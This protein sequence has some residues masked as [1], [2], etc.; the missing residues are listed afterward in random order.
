MGR[1]SGDRS[2][3]SGKRFRRALLHYGS[4][5]RYPGTDTRNSKGKESVLEM[6][7]FSNDKAWS[8]TARSGS[9]G[10]GGWFGMSRR[11]AN[12]LDWEARTPFF[13]VR[14]KGR[15]ARQQGIGKQNRAKAQ[16]ARDSGRRANRQTR[17]Q[18]NNRREY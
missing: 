4:S 11:E 14:A 13:A 1:R 10:G 12:H 18:R 2:N 16:A 8:D 6:G 9:G 3:G 17:S 15:E 7:W 5:A